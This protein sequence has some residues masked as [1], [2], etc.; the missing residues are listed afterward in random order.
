MNKRKK[1][2]RKEGKE[3]ERRKKKEKKGNL[4]HIQSVNII[5][6]GEVV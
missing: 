5:M 2:R 4:H 3:K 1:A 6:C